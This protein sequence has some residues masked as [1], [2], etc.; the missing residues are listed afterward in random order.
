MNTSEVIEKI[1]KLLALKKSTYEEL[2]QLEN[3]IKKLKNKID[4]IENK[5]RKLKKYQR[6]SNEKK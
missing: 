3:E 6:L 5:N 4:N 1:T 2:F